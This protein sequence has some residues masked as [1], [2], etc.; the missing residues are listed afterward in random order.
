M[1]GTAMTEA[2]EFWKVYKLDVVAVP[3]NR[4]AD[5]AELPDAI[6]RSDREK[7]SSILEEIREVHATGRPILVGTTSIEK[8]EQLSE[9]L[10]RHGITH[11][12]LNAKY[13][14]RE[15]EIVAVAGR[16]SAVT[17]ATNMAGRGTDIILGGNPEFMAWADLEAQL[18][19]ADGRPLYLT[20]L[21]VPQDV[22]E[23]AAAGTSPR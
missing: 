16:K 10:K 4:A 8:S 9:M 2:N 18:T 21:E 12:V 3:T 22:W 23:E 5:P 14:G 13:H 15:A 11:Q 17:I 19:D 20:R 1:T 7:L 6:Y